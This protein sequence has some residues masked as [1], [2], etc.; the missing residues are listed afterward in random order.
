MIDFLQ[1]EANI[2]TKEAIEICQDLYNKEENKNTHKKEVEKAK[3]VEK[4]RK[5]EREGRE[6]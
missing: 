2:S 4:V 1:K 3:E 5:L 6:R